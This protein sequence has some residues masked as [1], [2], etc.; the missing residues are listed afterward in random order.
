MCFSVYRPYTRVH[1]NN[2]T[3]HSHNSVMDG[4]SQTVTLSPKAIG[5]SSARLHND[6]KICTIDSMVNILDVNNIIEI[7]HYKENGDGLRSIVYVL[8]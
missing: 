5:V 7:K 4:W 1:R 8:C 6:Y 2:A 3:L